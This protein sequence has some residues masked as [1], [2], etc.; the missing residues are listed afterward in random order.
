MAYF[1]S[2]DYYYYFDACEDVSISV[3]WYIF[4]IQMT[5]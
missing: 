4:K 1:A 3:E 2:N 5:H